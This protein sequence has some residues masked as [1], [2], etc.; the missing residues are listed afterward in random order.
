M[1]TSMF[2]LCLVLAATLSLGGVVPRSFP[3]LQREAL[4]SLVKSS[5]AFAAA[6]VS[7]AATAAAVKATSGTCT[8]KKG[9]K[10]T[11]A[12]E[13]GALALREQMDQISSKS[14]EGYNPRNERIY[15]TKKKSFVPAHPEDYLSKELGGSNV[16]VIGEVHSNRCHHH[17]EFEMVRALHQRSKEGL[18]MAI[19]LE[20]FYRQHQVSQQPRGVRTRLVSQSHSHSHPHPHPH[21]N[22]FSHTHH[23]GGA[24]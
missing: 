6:G 14:F 11:C 8:C 7:G 15:N 22:L 21:S 5:A 1:T 3:K 10:C 2:V 24:R 13:A 12:E 19:G 16:V 20:C 4:A 23:S 17:A 9:D 18:G